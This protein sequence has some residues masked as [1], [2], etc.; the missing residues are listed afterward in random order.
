MIVSVMQLIFVAP[1]LAQK[2]INTFSRSKIELKWCVGGSRAVLQLWQG[3]RSVSAGSILI[4]F[5]RQFLESYPDC[6]PYIGGYLILGS[7]RQV[8]RKSFLKNSV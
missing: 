1:H 2:I 4:S 6:R 7:R 3:L 5:W 8:D